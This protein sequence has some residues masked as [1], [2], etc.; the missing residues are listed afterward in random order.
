MSDPKTIKE[1]FRRNIEALEKRP[2]IGQ[3][4]GSTTVRLRNGT[5]CEI[6]NGSKNLVCDVGK[7]Q[8][9]NDKGPGPGVLERGAL[10][11]CLAMGYSMWAAYLNIPV[12]QIEVRIES[13]FDARAMFGL[14]NKPPGFA[15]MRY[16]VL[17]DSPADEG[18]VQ[19]LIEKADAHSPVLDDFKRPVDVKR[20]VRIQTG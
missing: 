15:E 8:G 18:T 14:G 2:S 12:D 4:T 7:E 5:T 10:G 19:E 1:V 11:S 17:I 6:L 20:K 3:S 16:D 13:D 9:G